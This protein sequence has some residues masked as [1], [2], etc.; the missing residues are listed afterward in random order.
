MLVSLAARP[1]PPPDLE[2]DVATGRIPSPVGGGNG[3]RGAPLPRLLVA[4]AGSA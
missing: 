4:F 2:D 1:P 3:L